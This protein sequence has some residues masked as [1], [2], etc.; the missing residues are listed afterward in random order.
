MLMKKCLAIFK[1]QIKDTLKNKSILIQFILFPLMAVIMNNAV[2]IEGMPKN[3][4]VNLFATMYIGM[5]PMESMSTIISEEK[6]NNT[7]R[8]LLMANVKTYEYLLGVGF[9]VLLL[10]LIGSGVFGICGGYEG[11]NLVR[12][13][14]IMGIGIIT[15]ILIGAA[16]GVWSKNQM[17]ATSITVPIMMIFSF[18][19]ML[20]GFNDAIGKISRFLYSQQVSHLLENISKMTLGR[21]CVV[22]IT[23]N[24]LVALVLFIFSYKR[25]SLA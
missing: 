8:V 9:Y 18:M 20:A 11:M 7:L 13:I 5:A 16:I 19:P 23:M 21:E 17:T 2:H 1:K 25:C 14:G 3:Y 22:V 15:S 6:E 10:C 4:F 12:F 24:I